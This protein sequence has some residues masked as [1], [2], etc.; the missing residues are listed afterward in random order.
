MNNSKK[1]EKAIDIQAAPEKVFHTLVDDQCTRQWFA[2]FGN[3]VEGPHAETDWQTGSKA[4]FTDNSGGGMIARVVENKPP[5][6]LIV[7]YTGLLSNGVEDY[8]SE[9][10]KAVQGGR[11]VYH[12]TSQGGTTRLAIESD[13]SA[14]YYDMMN[15]AWD[16]A[17]QTIKT[18]AESAA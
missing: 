10:A 3:G 8:D 16:A 17:L 18:L 7:E 2:A 15:T 5:T 11:E 1:I 9:G 13:M 4:V 6:S 14:E 12:L